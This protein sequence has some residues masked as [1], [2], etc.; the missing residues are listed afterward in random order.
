M[1]SSAGGE[2]SVTNLTHG[3]A[4][5]LRFVNTG[6]NNWANVALDGHPFTVIASD[7]VPI[8][9][10]TTNT[11]TIAVGKYSQPR[12][13]AN[14]TPHTIGASPLIKLRPALRR[15][16]Q[17]QSDGW[18]LLASRRPGR[19]GL[20]RTKRQCSEHSKHLPLRRCSRGEP[21]LHRVGTT[22]NRLR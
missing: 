9:P 3:K 18:Q 1:T 15:H 2:Y 4:H 11:L 7:F 16:H 20:R 10:Y 17:R 19:W 21:Q 12:V 5:L 22:V 13:Y 14:L 6:I 8:V